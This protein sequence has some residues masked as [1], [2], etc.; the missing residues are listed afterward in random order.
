LLLVLAAHLRSRYGFWVV[1]L[2]LYQ[3]YVY[4][5]KMVP[6]DLTGIFPS[7]PIVFL[8]QQQ[9]LKNTL[10]KWISRKIECPNLSYVFHKMSLL[11][12]YI[13]KDY[14][15]C[16]GELFWIRFPNTFLMEDSLSGRTGHYGTGHCPSTTYV[17]SL[18]LGGK[19]ACSFF[20]N[21]IVDTHA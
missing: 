11:Y 2:R 20:F 14:R 16:V 15:Y 7:S 13:I 12:N 6:E 18:V 5:Y 9:K 3:Q 4:V 1:C 21:G 10:Y 19:I 17:C 8:L